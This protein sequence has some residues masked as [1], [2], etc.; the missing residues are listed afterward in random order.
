MRAVVIS[1][2]SNLRL[3]DIESRALGSHELRIAVAVSTV[4]GSDLKMIAHPLR[5]EGQIPG[6]EFSGKV[7]ESYDGKTLLGERVTVF[8]MFSCLECDACKRRDYRDCT[9]KQSLGFDLQGSFAEEVIVD[10]RF[11]VRLHD[12]ISYEDGALVEH[13]CCGLRLSKE[14]EKLVRLDD[15][16]LIVGDGPMALADLR[17][18]KM[19]GFH[20]ITLVGKHK[21]RMAFAL[22]LDAERVIHFDEFINLPVDRELFDVLIFSANNNGTI[23]PLFRWLNNGVKVFPQARIGQEYM[24]QLAASTGAIFGRAFA[25]HLDDFQEVMDDIVSGQVRAS[26]L[27]SSRICL[28][29]LPSAV[30][31]LFARGAVKT[32]I[33]VNRF[34]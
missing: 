3:V 7:V 21:E 17:F 20:N 1:S 25:Y 12:E 24:A 34:I 33:V 30:P 11:A 19:R 5:P 10:A 23:D 28:H 31:L 18:L 8:P 29:E 16:I 22:S 15:R 9:R 14:V 6:H 4:C 26:E 32:M 27:I 2:A 13:L